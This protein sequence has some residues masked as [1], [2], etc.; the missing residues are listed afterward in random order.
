MKWEA[1]KAKNPNMHVC[2]HMDMYLFEYQA[3]LEKLD[4]FLSS[5]FFVYLKKLFCSF[6]DLQRGPALSITDPYF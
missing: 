5:Y 6:Q 1:R 2:T 4:L 3:C